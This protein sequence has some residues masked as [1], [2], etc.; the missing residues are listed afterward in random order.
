MIQRFLVEFK[1]VT[2]NQIISRLRIISMF[3]QFLEAT[4]K[5]DNLAKLRI[6]H[7]VPLQ[8]EIGRYHIKIGIYTL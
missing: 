7:A 2:I 3:T 1:L 6:I 4:R 5:G 8:Q